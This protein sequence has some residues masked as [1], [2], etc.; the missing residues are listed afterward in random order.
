M[1]IKS[2][3]LLDKHL[4]QLLNSLLVHLGSGQILLKDRLLERYRRRRQFANQA[5]LSHQQ[6]PQKVHVAQLKNY[7]PIDIRVSRSH[8]VRWK[9][10]PIYYQQL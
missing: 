4:F 1:I 3:P 2:T 9:Y 5:Q 6:R 7:R 8:I 10:Q